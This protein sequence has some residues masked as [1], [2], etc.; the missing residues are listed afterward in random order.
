MSGIGYYEQADAAGVDGASFAGGTE[1]M[2]YGQGMSMNPEQISG[3][4]SNP[5]L[6]LA[7]GGAAKACKSTIPFFISFS[8]KMFNKTPILY[9]NTFNA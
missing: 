4:F 1:I 8:I 3:V 2:F 9:N 7:D 6:G 5:L